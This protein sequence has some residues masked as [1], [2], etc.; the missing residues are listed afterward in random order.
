MD[1]TKDCVEIFRAAFRSAER[2]GRRFPAINRARELIIARYPGL[3]DEYMD[4]IEKNDP[5][6]TPLIACAMA[7]Q[8]VSLKE[9][10]IYD[11]KF[12]DL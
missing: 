2:T 12:S 3:K 7:A 6:K 8:K 10:S 4:S 9:H 11:P 1:R 5:E